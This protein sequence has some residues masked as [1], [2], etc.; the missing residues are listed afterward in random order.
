MGRVRDWFVVDREGM[1]LLN[2]V[3]LFCCAPRP[4][5]VVHRKTL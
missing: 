4:G 2:E 5:K 3:A 1:G